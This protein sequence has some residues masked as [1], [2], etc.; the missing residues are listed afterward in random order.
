MT[1]ETNQPYVL[2][3]HAIAGRLDAVTRHGVAAGGV[4][5]EL[6]VALPKSYGK[7]RKRYPLLFVLD[8]VELF[9][10]AVEMSRL[11]A[12]TSEIR[13]CI[14]VGLPWLYTDAAEGAGRLAA[15]VSSEILDWCRSQYRV[16]EGEVALFG[17]GAA[18]AVVL[19]ALLSGVEGIDR[20]IAAEH[21][22]GRANAV[23]RRFKDQPVRAR[24]GRRLS[25]TVTGRASALDW[26]EYA[27]ALAAAAGGVDVTLRRQTDLS[28]GSLA[29]PALLDGLRCFWSGNKEYGQ[30]IVGMRR[31]LMHGLMELLSPLFR[32]LR[33]A[34]PT[35]F[36]PSNP[37]LLRCEAMDRNFEVFVSLPASYLA[38][39]LRRYPA[40]LVLDANIEFATV[41]ETSARMAAA[42]E[43]AETIVI[44]LGSPRSEGPQEF[45][46]RRFEE[47]SPPAPAGYAYT[48]ALGRIFRG[49]FAVRGQDARQRLGMA[50]EMH[51]F[52]TAELLP[53]LQ[54]SLPIDAGDL[55][56]LGHSAG[57]TFVGY[58]LYQKDS[59]FR[60]YCAVS[61]GIGI[62]D[63][64]MLKH[65]QA[66]E[67]AARA[68]TV[69]LT[70][71]S[72]EKGNH[73]NR[74]AGIDRTEEFGSR[75]QAQ[76][77]QIDLCCECL[78]GETHSSIFPR[79]V[80]LSLKTAYGRV[81]TP[82]SDATVG[83][84]EAA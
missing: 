40:L 60:R 14:V 26:Q 78:N 15:A 84:T 72:L 73:F 68:R 35:A 53:R 33:R 7:G 51:R 69:V 39:S 44:G 70:I 34:P 11:M 79:A 81:M 38:A 19:H 36:D 2:G 9:G 46:F 31:P 61:P 16:A 30:Q 83:Q 64:W 27:K 56:I 17:S 74:I 1:S 65:T 13:E 29:A 66:G 28:T 47:F 50:P 67:L 12:D 6:G 71:G 22:L 80:A 8:A 57:G 58:A 41:A 23:L 77:P 59:P 37:Q 49:L 20:Y 4:M 54:Q 63:S 42:G 32:R 45:G 75:L 24:A 82:A 76:A 43:I 48:D 3:T 25:L 5:R 18:A 62:S 55:G 21:D 10:S 52:I